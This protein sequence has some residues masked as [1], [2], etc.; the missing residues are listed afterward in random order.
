MV[1]HS[2]PVAPRKLLRLRGA[3]GARAVR[4][5]GSGLGEGGDEGADEGSGLV[6]MGGAGIHEKVKGEAVEQ[7]VEVGS[8]GGGIA[9]G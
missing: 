9:Y 2:G 6:P 3:G 4:A 5:R 7:R 1:P 8:E